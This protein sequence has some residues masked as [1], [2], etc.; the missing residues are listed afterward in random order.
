MSISLAVTAVTAFD[1]AVPERWTCPRCDREFAR[2]RQSRVCVPG[3]A[4]DDTFAD[5]PA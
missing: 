1:G 3:C 5:Q 2:A 4:V